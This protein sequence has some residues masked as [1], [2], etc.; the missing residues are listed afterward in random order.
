MDTDTREDIKIWSLTIVDE[1]SRW[2]EAVAINSKS[3]KEIVE[4]VDTQWF[5]RYPR[6]RIYIHDNGGEFVGEEFQELLQSYDIQSNP[7][8]VKNPQG[9]AINERAHLVMGEMIRTMPTLQFN[10]HNMLD[11]YE[12]KRRVL[13]SQFARYVILL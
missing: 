10:S 2:L 3:A 5:C 4:L 1:T 8:T 11:I 13:L 12:T 6:P 7:T 9:N